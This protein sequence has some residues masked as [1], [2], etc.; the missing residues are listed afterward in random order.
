[1]VFVFERK[2]LSFQLKW[3][4]ESC[5]IRCSQSSALLWFPRLEAP[6]LP[7][8]RLQ[9]H[10][11]LKGLI[12][13]KSHYSPKLGPGALRAKPSGCAGAL[14]GMQPIGS[15]GPR[16]CPTL[17]SPCASRR[18]TRPGAQEGAEEDGYL[19]EHEGLLL[20]QEHLELLRAQHLLLQ[21]LLHLLGGD[22]L[23]C[24]HSH[25]HGHLEG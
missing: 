14:S 8:K 2:T 9:S 25:W 16:G 12:S 21:D 15:S 20:L 17:G 3:D 1:M 5:P 23:R 22:H 10:T 6:G 24:H 19:L 7:N 18:S 4:C 11:S 13:T